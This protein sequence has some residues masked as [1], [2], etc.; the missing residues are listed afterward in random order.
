MDDSRYYSITEITYL[1]RSL[2]NPH[3][4]L[5]L[6]LLHSLLTK[7]AINLQQ[8]EQHRINE[9]LLILLEKGKSYSTNIL[10][11][12]CIETIIKLIMNSYYTFESM[13]RKSRR[14]IMNYYWRYEESDFIKSLIDKGVFELI[15]KCNEI[16]VIERLLKHLANY[17]NKMCEFIMKSEILKVILS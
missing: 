4:L 13:V 7:N 5:A 1:L 3:N 15:N 12:C 6:N 2:F 11:L 10:L 8:L 9:V 16:T 17:S 14:G